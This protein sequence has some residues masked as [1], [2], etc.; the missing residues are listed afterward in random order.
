M[1][2]RSDVSPDKTLLQTLREARFDMTFFC[3][4]G[5]CDACRVT[6]CAGRAVHTGTGLPKR[7]RSVAM[8]SCVD[9]G[10]GKIEIELD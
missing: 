8:L 3:E 1:S 9:R 10:I 6:L 2:C 4:S 7:D 5:N